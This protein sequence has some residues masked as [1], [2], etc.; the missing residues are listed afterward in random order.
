MARGA[1]RVRIKETAVELFT[2]QGYDRTSLRA[3]AERLDVTKAAVYY[4]FKTKEGILAEL[5]EEHAQPIE[6]VIAW[7]KAQSPDLGTR[8]EALRRYDAALAQAAPILRI[9]H[10]NQAGLRELAVGTAY[11][12][13][14]KRSL[15]V[16][17]PPGADLVGQVRTFAALIA[18]H[19]ATRALNDTDTSIEERRAAAVAVGLDLLASAH[20]TDFSTSDRPRADSQGGSDPSPHKGALSAAQR[21]EN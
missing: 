5:F 17:R 10:E 13:L 20:L 15:A 18:V 3:I 11:R 8:Q 6:D 7:A 1:T 9:F 21:S 19:T 12:G 4:H 16:L 2:E 14:W